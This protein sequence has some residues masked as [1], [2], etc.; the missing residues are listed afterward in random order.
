MRLAWAGGTVCCDCKSSPVKTIR[1]ND[2]RDG[3]KSQ[4]LEQQFST[5]GS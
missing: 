2:G 5:S 4:S 1:R 3:Q